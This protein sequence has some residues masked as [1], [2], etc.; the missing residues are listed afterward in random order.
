MICLFTGLHVQYF[1]LRLEMPAC[2]RGSGWKLVSHLARLHYRGDVYLMCF[3]LRNI[4][5]N[6]W[7]NIYALIFGVYLVRWLQLLVLHHPQDI[8]GGSEC[9][10]LR[11]ARCYIGWQADEPQAMAMAQQTL[12]PHVWY[13]RVCLG[14]AL[15]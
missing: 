2:F 4:K 6:K 14:H 12:G 11:V 1:K 3:A 15:R 9:P 7:P 13:G 10:D 8:V 5:I